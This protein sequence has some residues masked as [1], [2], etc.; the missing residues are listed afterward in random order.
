VII[1]KKISKRRKK[2][3]YPPKVKFILICITLG[4]FCLDFFL[5]WTILKFSLSPLLK[6]IFKVMT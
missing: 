6:H 4:F 2:Y 1:T 5:A 3:H